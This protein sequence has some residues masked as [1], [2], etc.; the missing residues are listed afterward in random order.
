MEAEAPELEVGGRE[1][2]VDRRDFLTGSAV[3]VSRGQYH[4]RE[5]MGSGSPLRDPQGGMLIPPPHGGGTD[6]VRDKLKFVGQ[7]RRD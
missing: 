4:L 5:E 2:R 7:L 6:P 1:L 3:T